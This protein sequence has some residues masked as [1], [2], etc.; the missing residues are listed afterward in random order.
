M[1]TTRRGRPLAAQPPGTRKT[2][3]GR[4]LIAVLQRPR[5]EAG[6]EAEVALRL[7]NAWAWRGSAYG[8]RSAI[9]VAIAD[10]RNENL[11]MRTLRAC[12]PHHAGML[13]RLKESKAIVVPMKELPRPGRLLDFDDALGFLIYTATPGNEDPDEYAEYVRAAKRLR[14]SDG[15]VKAL[16]RERGPLL[17]VLDDITD[18]ALTQF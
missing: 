11:V 3:L 15:V 18:L 4:N 5:E 7:M 9:A 17:L 14:G 6:L 13:E 1:T 8:A 16:I 2:V 12:F 10:P